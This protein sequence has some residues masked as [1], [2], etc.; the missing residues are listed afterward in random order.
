MGKGLVNGV[1]SQL[2]KALEEEA[3]ARPCGATLV[4]DGRRFAEFAGP[5]SGG[6]ANL[7]SKFIRTRHLPGGFGLVDKVALIARSLISLGATS[8]LQCM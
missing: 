1:V 7:A 6:W 8:K 3:I 5:E 2:P 4:Y